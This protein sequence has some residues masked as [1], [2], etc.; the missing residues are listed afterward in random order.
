MKLNWSHWFYT[1]LKTVIG[2]VA[3]TGSAWLGTL[4][5]NQ[6]DAAIPVLQL[7][8]LWSVLLSSTILN[9][10]FF[11][12]DSPLPKDQDEGGIADKLTGWLLIALVSF[13]LM[14]GLTGCAWLHPEELKPVAIAPGQDAALVNAER[15]QASS[16]GVYHELIVWETTHRATLPAEVSRAV[17]RT[18]REFP[19]AW[20]EASAILKDYRSSRTG[21]DGVSRVTAA[22]A[23][24]QASMLRLKVD[25]AQSNELLTALTSL[26]ESISTLKN[27]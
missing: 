26:S 8:Q 17:D 12:K 24:A 1:L 27:P 4:I 14:F 5:G 6:A 7:N 9:L 19:K 11:L 20:R 10:F 25:V 15:I 22:M 3:A 18:R 23:S 2:G 21:L 13:G 16:L